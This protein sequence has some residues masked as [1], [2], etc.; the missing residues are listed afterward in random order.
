MLYGLLWALRLLLLGAVGVAVGV[1]CAALAGAGREPR[2]EAFG[3]C[4]LGRRDPVV[5]ARPPL[6]F[7]PGGRSSVLLPG[8]ARERASGLVGVSPAVL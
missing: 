3:M 6:F 7:R 5:G 8:L 1:G 2:G 4:G